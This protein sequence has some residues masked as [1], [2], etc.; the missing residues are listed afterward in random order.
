MVA[1]SNKDVSFIVLL[2]GTGV[3]GAVINDYQNTLPMKAAGV[4]DTVIQ[5]YLE[6]HH[7]LVKAATSVKMMMSIKMKFQ[8]YIMTG[9]KIN[10]LKP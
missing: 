5:H 10:R 7:A 6:L 1:A 2:A 9:K 3:P 4:S 8:K